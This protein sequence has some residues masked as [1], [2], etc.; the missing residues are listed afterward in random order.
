MTS[1]EGITLAELAGLEPASKPPDT[2][3]RR[4]VCKAVRHHV[5]LRALLHPVVADLRGGVQS[6]LNV[7]LFQNPAFSICRIGPDAGQAVRLK[8][9]PNRERIGLSL[10]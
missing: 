3:F 7:S 5:T 9:K 2:L 10:V 1:I 8:L 4:T 6:L